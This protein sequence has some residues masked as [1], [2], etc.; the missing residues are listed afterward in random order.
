MT[1]KKIQTTKPPPDVEAVVQPKLTVSLFGLFKVDGHG[2]LGVRAAFIIA[3]SLCG[4]A[5]A[6]MAL[7][8]FGR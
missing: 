6:K 8:L 1:P 4:L 2:A 3:L 7:T 5:I